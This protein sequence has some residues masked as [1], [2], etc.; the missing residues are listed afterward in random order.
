MPLLNMQHALDL[1]VDWQRET[2]HRQVGLE[3]ALE[4]VFAMPREVSEQLFAA[5]IQQLHEEGLNGDTLLH[6]KQEYEDKL[7]AMFELSSDKPPRKQ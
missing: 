5:G 7:S 3:K 1:I 2:L 6:Y 4:N